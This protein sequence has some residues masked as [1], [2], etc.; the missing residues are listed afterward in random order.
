[1]EKGAGLLHSIPEEEHLEDFAKRLGIKIS[2]ASPSNPI[3]PYAGCFW[4]SESTLVFFRHKKQ[5]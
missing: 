5:A 2:Y 1:M 4:L 3:Y